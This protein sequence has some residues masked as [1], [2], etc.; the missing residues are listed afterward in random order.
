MRR[1]RRWRLPVLTLLL[2]AAGAAMPWAVFRAQDVYGENRQEERRLDSFSLTLREETD[3]LSR[4]LRIIQDGNYSMSDWAPSAK[5]TEE[6]ALGAVQEV[7]ELMADF[8]LV[9]PWVPENMA[10]FQASLGAVASIEDEGTSATMWMVYSENP[11]DGYNYFFWLDDASGKVLLVSV[12]IAHMEPM[13][14]LY[15][16]ME[17]WRQFIEVYY[18]V[19]ISKIGE[20]WYDVCVEFYLPFQLTEAEEP[21]QMK[22]SLYYADNFSTLTPFNY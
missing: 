5:L 15:I 13:E 21:L 1:L 6:E 2:M 18:G 4:T 17:R 20:E 3:I 14:D 10:N 9:E 16:L 7:M 19:E 8:G 12:P 22:L 11:L